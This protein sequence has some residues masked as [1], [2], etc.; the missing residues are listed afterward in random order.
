MTDKFDPSIKETPDLPGE[1]HD[2]EI[3]IDHCELCGYPIREEHEQAWD[4]EGGHY[5]SDCYWNAVIK[6]RGS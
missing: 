2:E 1:L 5:H 6:H 3:K 4:T